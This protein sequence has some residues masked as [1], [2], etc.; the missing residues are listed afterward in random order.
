MKPKET[1]LVLPGSGRWE[2]WPAGA[3][4]T[5]GSGA[6]QGVDSPSA[7]PVDRVA[8]IGLPARYLHALPVWIVKSDAAPVGAM[9][10]A[11]IERRALGAPTAGAPQSTRLVADEPARQLHLA[12]VLSPSLPQEICVGR[13]PRFEPTPAL[14][15]LPADRLVLWIEED[16]FVAAVSRGEKLA[17]F[18]A[19]GSGTLDDTLIAEI[20]CLLLGLSAEGVLTR[21]DGVVMWEPVS[22]ERRSALQSALKL[23][24]E[25]APRPHPRLPAEVSDLRP[26]SV[27]LEQ[28]AAARRRRA[29]RWIALAGA[30]YLVV[31][32]SFGVRAFLK[33]R[34][35]LALRA[36][37][38]KD[39]PEIAAVRETAKRWKS[40]EPALNPD[41]YPIERLF[42]AATLLPPEGVRLILLEQ[43][44]PALQL[45]GEARNAPAAFEF[46]E[47]LKK[48]PAWSAYRWQM[49]QPKLLA[50]GSAQFQIEG[51]RQG[52]GASETP[53]VTTP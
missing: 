25:F 3:N 38:A 39:A 30:V 15:P 18:Q 6:P 16:R 22:E 48:A 13:A 37:L 10:D 28:S 40:L 24:V 5:A 27:R 52:S 4:G 49:P 2:I 20:R 42:Q 43:R 11:Q 17:Y 12:T 1:T 26:P 14:Y 46:L 50:N 33:Y 51:S 44:G 29:G 53:P 21:C 31:L 23:P 32:A 35:I 41:H 34:E 36:E 19:L 7:A 8:C 47:K 45:T 9:I